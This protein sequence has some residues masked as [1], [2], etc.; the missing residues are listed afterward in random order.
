M[1][2]I[3][4]WAPHFKMGGLEKV[5]VFVGNE[6]STRDNI[7]VY[8]YSSNEVEPFFEMNGPLIFPQYTLN[9]K[10]ERFAEKVIGKIT[11]IIKVDVSPIELDKLIIYQFVEFAKK[12][13]LDT[14]VLNAQHLT[15]YIPK[16]KKLLPNVKFIAW[17]HNNWER[18]L[19]QKYV[20]NK[21]PYQKYFIEGLKDAD[22]IVCLTSFDVPYFSRYNSNTVCINNPLTI[23]ESGI[24]NLN[25]KQIAYIGR[26]SI[27]GKG[28]D[29]MVEIAERLPENWRIHFAGGGNN[30]QENKF[31][32][33]IKEHGVIDNI[34]LLGRKKDD[35]I[36]ELF[37]KSSIYIMTSRWEGMP[38]VLAEAMSFGLP[39]IAFDQIGSREVLDNGKF[40]ILIEQGNVKEMTI[41][42]NNLIADKNLR[43]EYSKKSLE[44]V[45]D[46]D[47][48]KIADKWLEII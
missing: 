35:G 16:L 30:K 2:N 3:C 15:T 39:I 28:L 34:I 5:N 20:K 19:L 29:Y 33:L 24:A 17:M 8:Y 9:E 22:K 48:K 36:K 6:L 32:K 40:G 26:I 25:K 43:E 38:L 7:N 47:I 13:K 4:F 31:K 21:Y 45:K 37:E 41:Q 11:S 27:W 44:R 1:K 23:K 12:N 46:F 10:V 42:L 18:Y 14:V